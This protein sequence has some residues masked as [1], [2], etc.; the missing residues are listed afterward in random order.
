MHN[1]VGKWIPGNERSRFVTAYLGSSIGVA[2]FYPLFGYIIKISSWE[3]VFHFSFFI[4]T[5]WFILWQYFVYD[6]PEEHP[7][8]DPSEKGYILKVLGSSVVR[9]PNEK[10]E[11]PWKS[12]LTS[13]VTWVSTVCQIGGLW[14]LFTLVTQTPAYFRFIHGWSVEMTGLLSGIPH[15]LRTAFSMLISLTSDYLLTNNKMTRNNVR[16]LATLFREFLKI[17]LIVFDL[18]LIIFRLG[19]E[20]IRNIWLGL[21]RL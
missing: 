20:W 4:G 9:D 18:I 2:V 17:F 6:S 3:W 1:L 15:L 7:R 8:I 5:I 19:V 16:R 11:I 14:G 12:I 21:C 13:K 10:L